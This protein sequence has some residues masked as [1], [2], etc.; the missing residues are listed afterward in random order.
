MDKIIN[1]K[2]VAKILKEQLKEDLKQL[3]G[4]PKLV[5]I[6]VGDLPASNIY[7]QNKEKACREM[8]ITF[9]LIH[10]DNDV[11][12]NTLINKIKELNNDSNING[13]L[14]QL[15]L[16]N[17][18][19]SKIINMID[20]LKDVDGLTS[21]NIGKLINNEDT[22]ISCTPKG[23][24]KLLEHYHITIEGKHVV[25]VGRSNLVGKP[26]SYLFLNKDATV[27]ICHSKTKDLAQHTRQADIL[28]VAAG[29]KDLI[30]KDMIK[31]EA[32]LI[33]VGTNRVDNKLYGD[34]N[35]D[36]VYDKCSLITPVPGG[37]GP[38]TIV[39][40][41]DNVIECYRLQHK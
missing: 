6:Q 39:M 9:E 2:E 37:V 20:P 23:V 36:D 38:M 24:M 31:E 16:P 13:I 33:D 1:G 40:L 32:I 8:G 5:V 27:T 25:I 21:I 26:L 3:G 35:Y 18:I 15:P 7:I 41:L 30:N 29:H 12:N 22:I 4:I 14:V 11:D 17:H 19:D 34:I 28:V 10:Y